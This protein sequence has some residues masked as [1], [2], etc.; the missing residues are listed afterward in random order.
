VRLAECQWGCDTSC[1]LPEVAPIQTPVFR[2]RVPWEAMYA[3][4]VSQSGGCNFRRTQGRR[5]RRNLPVI[6]VN[7]M[8]PHAPRR[9]CDKKCRSPTATRARPPPRP[10][11][12]RRHAFQMDRAAWPGVCCI[13]RLR[14]RKAG[15]ARSPSSPGACMQRGHEQR[16][17]H[18]RRKPLTGCA[19]LHQR[20]L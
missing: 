13:T 7:C 14:G 10:N 16:T 4:A 5:N 19:A 2:Y 1:S 12:V 11:V 15:A 20:C 8:H 6:S 9:A 18:Y 3:G 17:P